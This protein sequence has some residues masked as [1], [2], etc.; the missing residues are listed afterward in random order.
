MKDNNIIIIDNNSNTVINLFNEKI[1]ELEINIKD[2]ST[3]KINIFNKINIDKSKIKINIGNNSSI[4][5]N[6]SYIN[7]KNYKLDLTTNYLGNESNI[8]INI[9]NLNNKGLS[10]I[11]VDGIVKNE[12][13][14]NLLEEKIKILNINNGKAICKPNMYIKTNKVIANH[15]NGIGNIN[16]EELFYLMSKGLSKETSIKL[17]CDGFLLN[18]IEDIDLK[19][20]IKEYLNWR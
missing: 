5:F 14:N 20:K 1:E 15:E 4:V 6:Y 13:K 9:S 16:E 8:V 7:E 10:E 3:L 19:N 12:C 18:I 11:T 2:N 17:I